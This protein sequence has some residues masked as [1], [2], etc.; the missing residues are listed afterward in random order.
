[1]AYSDFPRGLIEE[2]RKN[3]PLGNIKAGEYPSP[4]SCMIG[5]LLFIPLGI[6][7]VYV[8]LPPALP[9][10]REAVALGIVIAF[11]LLILMLV[12]SILKI[13]LHHPESGIR[14]QRIALGNI[15]LSRT[16]LTKGELVPVE[17][18]FAQPLLY[19]PSVTALAA[20]MSA[21]MI[22][23]AALVGLLAKKYIQVHLYRRYICGMG[24]IHSTMQDVY[25]ITAAQGVG[26]TQI[27]GVLEKQ[28]TDAL[29]YASASEKT[30]DW[31]KDLPVYD[32]VRAI[33]DRDEDNPEERLT[34]L[35]TKNAVAKGWGEM[36][37]TRRKRFEWKIVAA[38]QIRPEYQI[39]Q[40]LTDQLATLH[41]Q[42]SLAFDEQI[43]SGIN[44]RRIS[45]GDT[46]WV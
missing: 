45:H 27:A 29:T 16:W 17:M 25:V 19:P 43:Q 24:S 26:Q 5:F 46:V 2:W 20:G 8:F 21:V 39:V 28:I 32:L 34:Q 35:V 33:C 41:P 31:P 12:L 23:R 36:T 7:L 30:K 42:L 22:L 3:G 40:K 44:S 18:A 37:G 9:L 4:I 13:Q 11:G 15:E 38:D 1:M 6:Y 10:E 14:L